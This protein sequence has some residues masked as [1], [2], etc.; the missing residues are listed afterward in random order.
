MAPQ[1][2]IVEG[3]HL[4][5]L[6]PLYTPERTNRRRACVAH[7]VIYIVL[8]H[9]V[10]A[11]FIQWYKH[12]HNNTFNLRLFVVVNEGLVSTIGL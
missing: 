7:E 11:S 6:L 1:E 5:W 4:G 12:Q 9:H 2:H 3:C 10:Y 8:K